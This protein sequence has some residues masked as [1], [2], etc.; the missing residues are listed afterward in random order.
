M[1][2]KLTNQLDFLGIRKLLQPVILNSIN[3]SDIFVWQIE[4]HIMLFLKKLKQY[5]FEC[6]ETLS[7]LYTNR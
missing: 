3:W 2:E 1:Q 6:Q 4:I 5:V 7:I